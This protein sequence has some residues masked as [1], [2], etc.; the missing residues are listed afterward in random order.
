MLKD[1][2]KKILKKYSKSNLESEAAQEEIST[3]IA[4]AIGDWG[5][6]SVN[7]TRKT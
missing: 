7:Y 6:T 4:Q 1:V 2:V 3:K 5:L